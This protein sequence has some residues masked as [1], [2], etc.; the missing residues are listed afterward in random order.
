[1]TLTPKELKQRLHKTNAP[2]YFG[3]VTPQISGYKSTK[4]ME[5]GE[6]YMYDIVTGYNSHKCEVK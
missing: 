6:H 4:C 5:C 3:G 2:I 1:M